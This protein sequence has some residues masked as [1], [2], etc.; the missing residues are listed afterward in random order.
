[1][2][3]E[4]FDQ[5]IKQKIG[6]LPENPASEEAVAKVHTFVRSKLTP[7]P[8]VWYKTPIGYSTAALVVLLAGSVLWNVYQ[9]NHNKKLEQNLVHQQT[10]ATGEEKKAEAEVVVVEPTMK[11]P[12]NRVH[13]QTGIAHD[14][15][16]SA[17]N[18][19]ENKLTRL[20]NPSSTTTAA[21]SSETNSTGK[22]KNSNLNNRNQEKYE[23]N[24]TNKTNRTQYSNKAQSDNAKI[25]NSSLKSEYPNQAEQQIGQKTIAEVQKDLIENKNMSSE[26]RLETNKTTAEPTAAA[27]TALE[28]LPVSDLDLLS[29][30]TKKLV[31]ELPAAPT[32]MVKIKR[33]K[34]SL[35]TFRVGLAGNWSRFD[36]SIGLAA[37]Y[38]ITPRWSVSS[39]LLYGVN[40]TMHFN[41]A[42]DFKKARQ[43]EFSES[44]NPND[45]P[46]GGGPGGPTKPD[47]KH[48]RN[49]EF[50][51]SSLDLPVS[52]QYYIPF[53]RKFALY[54]T[55]GASMRLMEKH[56]VKF[57]LDTF[58]FGKPPIEFKAKPIE[59]PMVKLF[60]GVGVEKS[61][62]K[63]TMQLVPT[64]GIDN[65]YLKP[66]EPIELKY[67]LGIRLLYSLN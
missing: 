9:Y 20:D 32:P 17:Q 39:G 67:D 4:K 44:Y 51:K 29:I 19:K 2:K 54:P 41:N 49:I 34:K 42:E 16:T 25:A 66:S 52:V 35:G 28:G 3:S 6:E 48:L 22:Q 27:W 62:G 24:L 59:A 18:Q 46:G 47:D 38:F 64:I 21:S 36:K 65:F 15:A 37:Q 61:I 7:A 60:A 11:V 13:D 5:L 43:K 1:M 8:K 55:L 26:N 63:F 58:P 31:N 12:D 40:P 14:V 10:K 23:L 30:P 50:K 33:E 56:N 45:V 57:A 53:K